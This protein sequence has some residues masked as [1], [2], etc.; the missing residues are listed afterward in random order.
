MKNQSQRLIRQTCPNVV[1][2]LASNGVKNSMLPT[3]PKP[4][5]CST[6]PLTLTPVA[7]CDIYHTQIGTIDRSHTNSRGSECDVL[8][9]STSLSVQIVWYCTVVQWYSASWFYPCTNPVSPDFPAMLHSFDRTDQVL[10]TSRRWAFLS[11][12]SRAKHRSVSQSCARIYKK[13]S[14][15]CQR[16]LQRS[17]KYLAKILQMC[18]GMQRTSIQSHTKSGRK[19]RLLN[20]SFPFLWHL[21]KYRKE[22][23]GKSGHMWHR[24][25]RVTNAVLHSTPSQ[26]LCEGSAQKVFP[27]CISVFSQNN[28]IIPDTS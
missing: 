7:S 2:I 5:M 26:C 3:F 1:R 27:C 21:Q 13:S 22:W 8:H 6:R 24:V 15:I 19:M 11:F 25:T 9:V 4:C 16:I 14:S 28:Q 18:K 10:A 17:Y 12:G 23:Q 20:Y